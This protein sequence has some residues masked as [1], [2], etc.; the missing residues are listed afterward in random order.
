M[1]AGVCLLAQKDS[2]AKDVC[3]LKLKENVRR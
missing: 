3:A 2:L 1:I